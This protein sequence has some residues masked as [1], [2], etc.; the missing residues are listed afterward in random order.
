MRTAFWAKFMGGRGQLSKTG[1]HNMQ[2]TLVVVGLRC[3]SRD[4]GCLTQKN[5]RRES[6]CRTVNS[7]CP[8]QSKALREARIFGRVLADSWHPEVLRYEY[9]KSV[10]TA[11]KDLLIGRDELLFLRLNYPQVYQ[12]LMPSLLVYAFS[13]M[14]PSNAPPFNDSP[15][16]ICSDR[17]RV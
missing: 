15:A 10:S 5:G 17:R 8:V 9:N 12:Q 14:K 16:I 6:R 2:K 13:S 11:Y 7:R 3:L 1:S 4:Q